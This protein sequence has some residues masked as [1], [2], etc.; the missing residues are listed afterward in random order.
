MA[1]VPMGCGRGAGCTKRNPERSNGRNGYD[2]SSQ[3]DTLLHASS[4]LLKNMPSFKFHRIVIDQISL[5]ALT[6]TPARIVSSTATG[7]TIAMSARVLPTPEKERPPPGGLSE[8]RSG[9]LIRRLR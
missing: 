1:N 8:I 3:H 9:V 2:K 7:R 4:V 6:I 5:M